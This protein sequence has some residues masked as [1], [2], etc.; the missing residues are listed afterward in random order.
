MGKH[1]SKNSE[2]QYFRNV[3]NLSLPVFEFL[4]FRIPEFAFLKIRMPGFLLMRSDEFLKMMKIR[5]RGI[6]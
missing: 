6:S 1:F 4:K 5:R 2:T 3:G